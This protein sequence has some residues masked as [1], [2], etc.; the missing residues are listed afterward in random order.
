MTSVGEDESLQIQ[1]ISAGDQVTLLEMT[2]TF[3]TSGCG[4]FSG[5]YMDIAYGLIWNI[6]RR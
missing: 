4:G 2:D 5:Y 3:S 6:V 1:S